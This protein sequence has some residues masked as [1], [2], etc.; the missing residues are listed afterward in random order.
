[1]NFLT[2]YLKDVFNIELVNNSSNELL[3]QLTG[4][5]DV[6]M[7]FVNGLGESIT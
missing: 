1:M 3:E 2:A 4:L 6:N 7:H 5:I